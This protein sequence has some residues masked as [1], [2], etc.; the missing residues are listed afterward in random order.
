MVFFADEKPEEE[1]Y[2]LEKDP[3]EMHNL[4]KDPEY[5]AVLK[6]MR[7]HEAE[8][9]SENK[10]FGLE[11]LGERQPEIGLAAEVAREGVKENEPELWERLE[12]GELLETHAWMGK[13]GKKK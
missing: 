12:T 3:D 1:L 10:D 13:Y 2:D 5:A 7:A 11:D 6:E 4:A 8:W 9:V